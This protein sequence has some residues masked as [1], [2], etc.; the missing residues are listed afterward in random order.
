MTEVILSLIYIGGH[1][2][3]GPHVN[4]MQKETYA[5]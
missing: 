5:G 4:D 1:N 2:Q 3:Y